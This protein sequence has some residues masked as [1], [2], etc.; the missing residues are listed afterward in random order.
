MTFGSLA[1]PGCATSQASRSRRKA[2]NR[3]SLARSWVPESWTSTS[4]SNGLFGSE[5]AA[6]IK[7]LRCAASLAAAAVTSRAD[8]SQSADT[9]E[10]RRAAKNSHSFLTLPLAL[11]SLSMSESCDMGCVRLSVS[12]GILAEPGNFRSRFRTSSRCIPESRP[13]RSRAPPWAMRRV[14]RIRASR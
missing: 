10:V 11:A 3:S 14:R 4:G 12:L 6:R 9:V 13:S 2:V 7:T 5:P 8:D 1:G